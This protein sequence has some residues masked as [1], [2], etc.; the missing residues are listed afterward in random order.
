VS[1]PGDATVAHNALEAALDAEIDGYRDAVN[2]GKPKTA[3]TLLEAL[4]GRVQHTG[5]GRILFRIK[6]NIGHCHLALNDEARAAHWLAE[7]YHHAPSE[8]KAVANYALSFLLQRKNQEAFNFATAQ[9]AITPQNGWLAAYLIQAAAKCSDL[10]DPIAT[11]PEPLRGL[12]DVKAA[13]VDFLRSR[14]QV[15]AWWQAAKEAHANH[16]DNKFLIQCAAE[17]ELDELGRTDEF[18]EGRIPA[19]LKGRMAAAASKL[20]ELW[21]QRRLT[22]NPA[23]PDGVA[24]CCNLLIAYY[25][26]DRTAD[27]LAV[28][29]QAVELVPNDETLLQRAAIAG[30]EAGDKLFVEKLLPRLPEMG[31]GILIHFQHYASKADW[32][33]ILGISRLA[34]LAPEHERATMQT[35]GRLSLVMTSN[36]DGNRRQALLDV[37]EFA[38]TDSRGSVLVCNTATVLKHPDIAE[39]AYRQAVSL[40]SDRSHRAARAMVARCAGQRDDWSA[41]THLLDGHVDIETPSAELDLLVTAFTNETPVRQRATKFF[42]E[43]PAS[44]REQ[45]YCATSYGYLQSK[46]GDLREAEKWLSK[47]IESDPRNLTAW[48]GLFSVYVRQ[49]RGAATTIASRVEEIDLAKVRGTPREKMALSHFLRDCGQY[50]QAAKFAYDTIRTHPNEPEVALLYFGLFMSPHA[51]KM[52]PA[53]ATVGK[54]TWVVIQSGKDKLELLIEDGPDRPGD[55]L[56]SL[57]HPFVAPA[58]GLKAGE[59]FSQAKPFGSPETWQVVQVKHKYLHMLHEMEH[60]NV[61]FPDATGLYTFSTKDNDI[62]PILD[63]VKQFS[64]RN[65]KVADLYIEKHFPLSVVVGAVG[66]EVTGL[67]GYVRNLGH[68]ITACYGNHPERTAA[69]RFALN[70]PDGG[71]VLDFYTAWIAT[72]LRLLEPLRLIFPRLLVPRSVIDEFLELERDAAHLLGGESMSVGYQ[73]GQFTRQVR[74]EEET[75]RL[76]KAIEQRRL[77]LE[78]NCDVLPIEIPDDASELARVICE[79]CGSHTLDPAFLA[80]R[81]NR[82]LLSDDLFYRQF[83]ERACGVRSGIWLQAALNVAR[84][85]DLISR[86]DYAEALIGLAFCRHAHLAIEDLTLRD[87]L[88]SDDTVGLHKFAAVVDFLGTKTAEIISHVSVAKSFLLSVWSMELPDIQK[89]AASGLVLEKLLRNRAIDW[90]QIAQVLRSELAHHYRARSY[91][92]RWLRGHFL[93]L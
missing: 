45:S 20:Q 91:L 66:S 88:Q 11:I 40:I 60:F 63:Q 16:P 48:I 78:H 59:S 26:L 70:P 39:Q 49:G 56:Y 24:A 64:E 30:L 50:S 83:A 10:S 73:D 5:S 37:L 69:E 68:D 79:K 85:R 57:E 72:T 54:D 33:K 81:E 53:T 51:D 9:L 25:A 58:M 28:A 19:A 76:R 55:N 74:T 67:A 93:I 77:D 13:H 87:V 1:T 22:E 36:D 86:K 34:H 21:D 38:S 71:A 43:L 15:P 23:R 82:V 52:I 18:K 29:K 35:M 47:G 27:A 3:L 17:A 46:R 12:V 84:R 44:I 8:P 7:A 62:T 41:V 31:D 42:H 75:N 80:A 61:R 2:S 65:R 90:K 32:P 14:G 6:A 4:L 89:E 92:D